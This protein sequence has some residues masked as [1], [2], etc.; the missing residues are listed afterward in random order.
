[1]KFKTDSQRVPPKNKS[2]DKVG[3]GKEGIQTPR[4]TRD[5]GGLFIAA[6]IIAALIALAN[7][8]LAVGL[9]FLWTMSTPQLAETDISHLGK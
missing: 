6:N 2:G 8:T 5:Y 1:M 7:G 9:F 3:S 4:S